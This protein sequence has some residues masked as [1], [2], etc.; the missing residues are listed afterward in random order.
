MPF[1]ILTILRKRSTITFSVLFISL[2]G[3]A[4]GYRPVET[5]VV[6]ASPPTA[7]GA[8]STE[9]QRTIYAPTIG[10][11]EAEGG[12]IVLNCRSPQAITTTPTFYTEN[13]EAI[14]G[15]TISLQ[16]A[17]IRFVSIDSLIPEAHRGQHT[18][19][20]MSLSYYGQLMEVWAQITLPGAGQRGSSDVTFSPLN[21]TGS[22][23]Q[24]AIWWQ[25]RPGKRVIVLGNSS[26]RPIVTT[27]QFANGNVE[28]VNIPPLG[29]R[30]VRKNFPLIGSDGAD[31]VKLTTVGPSGSLKA[32]GYVISNILSSSHKFASS[33]RF[34]DTNGAAQQKLFA[35]NFRLKNTSSRLLL[36]NTSS[37]SLIATPKFYPQGDGE[38]AALPSVTL[39]AGQS[40]EVNLQPL[41]NAAA[42]RDDMDSVSVEIGN[43]GTAGSL[44]G[45]LY[46]K[47]NN[48]GVGYDIPLRDYGPVRNSTG[49]YPVRLDDDYGT[50]VSITNVGNETARFGPVLRYNGGQYSFPAAKLEVGRTAVFNIKKIRDQQ[51]PDRDGNLL[52]TNIT[53]AQFVWSLMGQGRLIGRSEVV[54]R[55]ENV[56]S[57]YSCPWTCCPFSAPEI[58]ITVQALQTSS[59]PIIFPGSSDYQLER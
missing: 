44:I 42:D 33:I 6:S 8:C 52:P 26:D 36:R 47:N 54:S 30:Y 15:D 10:L 20:G 34:Y 46:A 39:N 21:G 1:K 59:C 50:S 2:I 3:F 43:T 5:T 35:T 9:T 55:D 49:G 14:V 4:S 51:I 13:G 16:P 24:E 18:W 23:T 57:S 32:T 17:E 58:R 7:C 12:K 31:S 27:L 19:G 40:K 53:T 41:R 25:P 11:P 56:S 45:A 37:N 22:D 28:S 38:P 48:T 29:T